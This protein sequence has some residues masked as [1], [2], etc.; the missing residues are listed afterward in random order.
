MFLDF[1]DLC[2]GYMKYFE[3]HTCHNDKDWYVHSVETQHEV[4]S[5][6]VRAHTTNLDAEYRCN[7]V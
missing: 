7:L 3:V 6:R 4:I 1:S 5:V 2:D